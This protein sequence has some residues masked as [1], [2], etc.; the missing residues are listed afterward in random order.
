MPLRLA[1]R[2]P[3][4][5]EPAEF[6]ELERFEVGQAWAK[7]RNRVCHTCVPHRLCREAFELL[8]ETVVKLCQKTCRQLCRHMISSQ[9]AGLRTIPNHLRTSCFTSRLPDL[10]ALYVFGAQA[11]RLHEFERS[12]H[13]HSPSED[14]EDQ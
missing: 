11:A 3:Y 6:A 7:T 2:M 13:A 10:S 9:I 1:L 5:Q 4:A 8:A 14:D 12:W